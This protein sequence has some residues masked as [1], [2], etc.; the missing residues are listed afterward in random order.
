MYLMSMVDMRLVTTFENI[1]SVP[2]E[3]SVTEEHTTKCGKR[4]LGEETWEH[5]CHASHVTCLN[6]KVILAPARI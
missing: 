5:P 4:V 6:P 2:V 1:I 3:E